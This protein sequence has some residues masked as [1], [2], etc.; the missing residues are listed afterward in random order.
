MGGLFTPS[1]T[2]RVRQLNRSHEYQGIIATDAPCK[3]DIYLS[4]PKNE[5]PLHLFVDEITRISLS[6][7][8]Q[9][10]QDIITF[11]PS[12]MSKRTVPHF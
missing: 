5:F 8:S 12:K 9:T 4:V 11:Y 7:T 2:C 10:G 3:R 1:C 6:A